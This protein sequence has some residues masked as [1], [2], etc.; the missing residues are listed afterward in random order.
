MTSQAA[1]EGSVA[2][3]T[4]STATIVSLGQSGATGEDMEAAGLL[5][6]LCE[7]RSSIGDSINATD[8]TANG[9][10]RPTEIY[11][12]SQDEENHHP[13]RDIGGS[14]CT[15]A[16]FSPDGGSLQWAG[17]ARQGTFCINYAGMG[18]IEISWDTT[19]G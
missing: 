12:H 14:S 9:D 1:R 8:S 11:E 10:Y 5:S 6:Q 17:W 13:L 7:A 15:V 18:T 3:I 16:L 2:S 19:E 4:T